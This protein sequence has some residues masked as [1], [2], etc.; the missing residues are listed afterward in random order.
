MPTG[1]GHVHTQKWHDCWEKVQAQGHSEASAAAIC[2]NSLGE[3]SFVG[4][5]AGSPD[6]R[7]TDL[8]VSAGT[9][10]QDTLDGLPCTVVPVTA[11]VEGV[12]RAV[13][14]PQPELVR[15]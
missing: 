4:A 13:N 9:L 15:S 10:R 2:T 3:E 6:L 11:L 12:I 14:S 1:K 8:R 7:L 5:T